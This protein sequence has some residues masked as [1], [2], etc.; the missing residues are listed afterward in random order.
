MNPAEAE[1]GFEAGVGYYS[2]SCTWAQTSK[3]KCRKA[4]SKG[5]EAEPNLSLIKVNVLPG[6]MAVELSQFSAAE[7]LSPLCSDQ[8]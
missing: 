8:L 2:G 7:N 1:V 5:K 6:E 4:E 3:M